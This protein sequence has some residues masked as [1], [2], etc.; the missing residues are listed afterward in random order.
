MAAAVKTTGDETREDQ[1]GI[2]EESEVDSRRSGTHYAR[3][4]V[5]ERKY[6]LYSTS[7]QVEVSTQTLTLLFGQLKHQ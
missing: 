5:D 7:A 1:Q 4:M 3:G 6:S 2:Y